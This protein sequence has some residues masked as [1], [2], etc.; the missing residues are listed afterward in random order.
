MNN[1]PPSSPESPSPS[2][3]PLRYKGNRV[4]HP[5][6]FNLI[7]YLEIEIFGISELRNDEP[8]AVQN[9]DNFLGVPLRLE[10]F[11]LF[12]WFICVDSFLY[13][14]TFLP[15]RV[16]FA[17][18]RLLV[19]LLASLFFV[20]QGSNKRRSYFHRTHMF[21]LMRG[22]LFIWGIFVLQHFDISTV[23]H[24][25]RGQTMIKLYVLTAMMDI[26]DRLFGSFGQDAL[27]SLF[28]KTRTCPEK[29]GQIVLSFLVVVVYV[30]FHCSLFFFQVTTLTV[31]INSSDQAL[32]TVVILNNFAEIKSYVFKKFDQSSV[33][34]LACSDI[35]E[36]FQLSLFLGVIALVGYLQGGTSPYSY[37]IIYLKFFIG[38]TVADWTKHA[39]ISKFNN[40]KADVYDDFSAS[41]RDDILQYQNHKITLDPTHTIVS[42]LGI[43]QVF[44]NA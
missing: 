37:G 11:L 39:F 33:F 8:I 7:K 16:V 9:I 24:F 27:N 42:R 19:H 20:D 5:N 31:A 6:D 40:I 14:F 32:I 25:I 18:L 36:L 4:F 34:S 17:I 1:L 28:W 3:T 12:G 15:V 35:I 38:E 23:Y 10:S 41:L 22:I 13:V 30:A 21:D 43:S 2:S 44:Y 29:Y 26:L